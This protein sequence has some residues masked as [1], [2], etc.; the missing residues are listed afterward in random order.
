MFLLL[1]FTLTEILSVFSQLVWKCEWS[2][3]EWDFIKSLIPSCIFLKWLISY[4]A[5][6]IKCPNGL[7]QYKFPLYWGWYMLRF[8]H[9]Q[10]QMLKRTIY[11]DILRCKRSSCGL[12]SLCSAW[13]QLLCL[14][15]TDWSP[16]G[17]HSLILATLSDYTINHS[18]RTKS[19]T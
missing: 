3:W 9:S 7:R 14:G 10:I 18:R 6:Q 4:C 12:K 19:L 5:D 2:Q 17:G 11:S 16:N 8:S 15:H 1:T 13:T